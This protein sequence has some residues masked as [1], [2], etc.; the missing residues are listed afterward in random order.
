MTLLGLL[1]DHVAAE[2]IGEYYPGVSA[3]AAQDALNFA[4]YVDSYSA[5]AGAA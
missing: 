3:E 2:R 1:R 5:V 4:A